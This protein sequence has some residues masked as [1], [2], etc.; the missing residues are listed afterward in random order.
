MVTSKSVPVSELP[1]DEQVETQNSEDVANITLN[2]LQSTWDQ[3][4]RKV[5]EQSGLT[6]VMDVVPKGFFSRRDKRPHTL[7]ET[8]QIL[9]RELE[10]KGFRLLQKDK[11]IVVLDLRSTKARYIRPTIQSAEN[12]SE[13]SQQKQSEV[14]RV[15]HQETAQTSVPA[16]RH[17]DIA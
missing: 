7:E 16:T 12:E 17:A 5:A 15:S 6:L 11:F 13:Q 4:L 14:E 9:N 2:H 10:P 8:F 1:A 3:V